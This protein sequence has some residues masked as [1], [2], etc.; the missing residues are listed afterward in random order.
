M[1]PD[2]ALSSLT[3]SRPIT[4]LGYGETYRDLDGVI[5]K[6]RFLVC[7]RAGDKTHQFQ[8]LGVDTRVAFG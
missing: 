3:F 2:H 4:H 5:Q 6:V 8:G 7:F 1:S